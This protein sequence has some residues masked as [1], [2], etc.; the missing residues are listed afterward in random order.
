M[1]I[2][3]PQKDKHHNESIVYHGELRDLH[4]FRDDMWQLKISIPEITILDNFYATL[5]E[6]EVD[7]ILEMIL[8]Q[9]SLA[10]VSKESTD[11]QTKRT[12]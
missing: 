4:K 9:R 5:T 2:S 3:I 7:F 12:E 1:R 6:E 10:V 11:K 8:R